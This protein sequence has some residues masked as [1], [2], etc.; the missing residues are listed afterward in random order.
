MNITTG[1]VEYNKDMAI[2]EVEVTIVRKIG[3]GRLYKIQPTE[4]YLGIEAGTVR[5]T[6][7]VPLVELINISEDLSSQADEFCRVHFDNLEYDS[8]EHARLT[9][10]PWVVYQY[11]KLTTDRYV[12]PLDEFVE[13]TTH[14]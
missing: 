9:E 6:H 4:A 14:Y 7:I 3:T 5:V 8:T 2:K 13:H 1:Y 10:Q 11:S 12:M